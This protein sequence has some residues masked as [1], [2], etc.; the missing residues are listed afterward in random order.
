V[1]AATTLCKLPTGQ[2]VGGSYSDRREAS[3][4]SGDRSVIFMG[5]ST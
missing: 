5:V 2:T 3:L 1:E 4:L